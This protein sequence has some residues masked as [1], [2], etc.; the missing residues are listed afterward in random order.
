[1]PKMCTARTASKV[2]LI[3]NRR[4][5]FLVLLAIMLFLPSSA[6]AHPGKTDENGGHYDAST[7]EYHYHHGYPAHQH[8]NG[9]CPYDY[10][11][12]TDHSYHESSPSLRIISPVRTP[13]VK[14]TVGPSPTPAPVVSAS[15]NTYGV[16]GCAAGGGFFFI[17]MYKL[18]Q[19]LSLGNSEYIIQFLRHTAIVALSILLTVAVILIIDA[20]NSTSKST[21]R[22]AAALTPTLKATASFT[23]APTSAATPAPSPVITPA[24]TYACRYIAHKSSKMFHY[25]TCETVLIIPDSSRE[26]L[27]DSRDDLIKMGYHPCQRCHP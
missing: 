19:S 10:D 9:V 24:P 23:P 3:I 12:K 25:P 7:G 6:S 21:K 8:I 17:F 16:I 14:P 5:L 11:D 15:V 13:T 27:N 22:A 20:M 18:L 26:Y 2:G 4:V 1:M